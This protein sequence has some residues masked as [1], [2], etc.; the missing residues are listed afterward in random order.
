MIKV[1]LL[2][3]FVSS[4]YARDYPAEVLRVYDGETV[5]VNIN[6][7]LGIHKIEVLKLY[8]INAPKIQN[9]QRRLGKA[10]RDHLRSFLLGKWITLS[11]IKDDKRSR[12]GRLLAI[13]HIK[14]LNI[15]EIMLQ[16]GFVYF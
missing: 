10:S 14:E 11:T 7:G 4:A 1:L 13:I 16:D 9:S 8:G 15:N 6:L 3:L 12:D 5:T 2:L